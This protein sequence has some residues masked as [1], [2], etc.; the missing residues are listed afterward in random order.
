MATTE[1]EFKA[2]LAKKQGLG[3]ATGKT[4]EQKAAEKLAA[5]QRAAKEAK[6]AADKLAAE[7]AAAQAASKKPAEIVP[8]EEPS[9]FQKKVGGWLKKIMGKRKGDMVKNYARGGGVRPADNEYR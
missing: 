9:D 3:G 8:H 6:E 4:A 5:E 7:Q 1:E 2:R